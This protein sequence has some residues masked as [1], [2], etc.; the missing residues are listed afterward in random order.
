[1]KAPGVLSI[2]LIVV[3]LFMLSGV[4]E[5][6]AQQDSGTVLGTVTDVRTG[7]PV[8][9]AQILFEET[10]RSTAAD[11]SGRFELRFLGAGVYTLKAYRIGYEPL[12]RSVS[13][14]VSDTLRLH[15]TMSATPLESGEILVE[16]DR[17]NTRQL[18]DA[19]M[20]MEGRKLRQNLGTTIAETLAD[21]PGIAM[22]SMGPAPARPVLR[23]LGGERLL[24]LEDG[25]RT[26]D[27]SA[28]ST[29]HAVV[30]DPLTAE[31][32]EV[33]RGPAALVFGS[34]TLGGVVNV[35]RGYIP[36]SRPNRIQTGITLQGQSVNNGFSGGFGVAAPAGPLAVHAD[37]SMRM[38]GD[39]STPVGPLPNTDLWTGS[40]S[41]GASLSGSRG[42]FGAAGSYYQSEY[43]IPGGFVGAHP[44]GVNIELSRTRFEVRT[45]VVQPVPMIPRMEM[46]AVFSRYRHREFEANDALGIE[47]GLLSYHGTALFH[48]HP[49]GHMRKG[50]A[51][52]WS[53][54][55]DYASGGFSFTPNSTEWSVAGF[56]FQDLHFNRFTLQGGLR[57]DYRQ[58]T[59]TERID[60]SIG[61]VR[62]RSFGGVS[63]SLRGMV[64]PVDHASAGVT[65]MRSLRLPGIEELYSEGPHLAAY[66]FEVGNPDLS[67]EVGW[68]IETFGGYQ[69]SRVTASAAIYYNIIR[70]YIY[71]RNTGTTNVRTLLPI[72][73]QTGAEAAMFGA[74]AALEIRPY[75]MIGISASTSYTNGTFTDTRDPLPWIPPLT[76]KLDASVRIRDYTFGATLKGASRQNRVADLEE[77]T[78]GH[79][80]AGA[81]V[82]YHI[83][84]GLL[85]HTFDLIVENL[86]DTEHRDHLSRVK[87]IMPEPGRNVKLLYKLYF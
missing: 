39:M 1:M 47:F 70:N 12:I 78:D 55:R 25:G 40:G 51:G 67:S 8:A 86:T 80:V 42:S 61:L 18:V 84:T 81:Y 26:G 64:H 56:G 23:G 75:D 30:I 69:G 19:A 14:P 5:A 48:F 44:D 31:R 16:G 29:D 82:Q 58:V 45:D 34:N 41:I 85:L 49:N 71:P 59:P 73:Q 4:I 53:E 87:S 13:V 63:A 35:V 22:R 72:Y 46:R 52:I 62:Q 9:F 2:G 17:N 10:N 20:E 57:Y 74:E 6:Q 76:G 37:G 3:G 77:P 33:V 38:A 32:I 43:G 50:V 11:G 21:E 24:I 65:L 68:G 79:V 36:T 83:T 66:S 28:T 60:S 27:L 54:Y 15:L 7:E